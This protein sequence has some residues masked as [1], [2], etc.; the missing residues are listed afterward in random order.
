MMAHLFAVNTLREVRLS[1]LE[2][3]GDEKMFLK[4]PCPQKFD[5]SIN[6]KEGTQP[7]NLRPYPYSHLQKNEIEKM[8]AELSS[9]GVIRPSQSPFS[10]PALLVKKKDVEVD[11]R[12]FNSATV[13]KKYP[14]PTDY[15]R[16]FG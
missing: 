9:T 16:S 4:N 3:Q 6:L 15:R 2:L 14:I 11:Y 1:A 12:Q 5:H 7:I 8:I 13:K 10:S